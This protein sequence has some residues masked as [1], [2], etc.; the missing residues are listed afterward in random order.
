MTENRGIKNPRRSTLE[1]LE[2]MLALA[3]QL[4]LEITDIGVSALALFMEGNSI[5]KVASQLGITRSSADTLIWQGL[6]ELR[7]LDKALAH[8]IDENNSI[9]IVEEKYNLLRQAVGCEEA[10]LMIS[11]QRL[12]N[13][14]KEGVVDEKL[15]KRLS[16]SIYELGLSTRMCNVLRAGGKL[17]LGDIVKS[18]RSEFLSY[19]NLGVKG[20]AEIDKAIAD[21]GLTYEYE[22]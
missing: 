21:A 8:V 11:Q 19:R 3:N 18:K 22:L 2:K 13:K 17:T 20:L 6:Y 10:D 12:E 5:P 7:N 15:I 14:V 1:V 9:K 16:L 4:G